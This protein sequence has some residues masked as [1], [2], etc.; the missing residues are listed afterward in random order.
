MRHVGAG[1]T[2]SNRSSRTRIAAA[3]ALLGLAAVGCSGSHQG[4]PGTSGGPSTPVASPAVLQIDPSNGVT[5]IKPGSP[6]TVTVANGKLTKVKLRGADGGY[7]P[8]KWTHGKTVWHSRG[9]LRTSTD[10]TLKA[11]AVNADGKASEATSTFRTLKPKQVVT[12]QIF[13]AAHQTYGVGMPIILTFDHPITHKTAVEKALTVTSSKP[14]VG[15]WYWDG[16]QTLY[17]RTR[18]YWPQHTTVWFVAKLNGVEVAPGVYGD[19]TLRQTFEIGDS[20]IAVASTTDHHVEIYRDNKLYATWP[21][22]TGRPGDDT[23]NGTYLTIEKGNPVEMKGPGYDIMVPYSVRFTW[24][25]D[26]MHD[27]YWSVGEQGFTNV[28]HGCV[29]MSPANAAL[30]Y[31]WAVPGDPVTVTGSPRAGSW[32]NGWTVWFLSFKD[33]VKGS[34]T[35]MAVRVGPHGSQLVKLGSLRHVTVKSPVH[36]PAANNSLAG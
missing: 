28:S 26:Y 8:G 17:F 31:S 2:G 5:G 15:A 7:V 1:Q 20:V 36:G 16:D 22:S 6:V 23:P 33:I 25:G 12:T 29:N 18:K 34:A 30:Y 10:Y 32:G 13:E 24:S 35:G 11:I 19:H 21:I 4:Q 9:V 3:V 14:V 27:A